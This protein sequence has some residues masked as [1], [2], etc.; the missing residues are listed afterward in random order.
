MDRVSPGLGIKPQIKDGA[1]YSDGT[2]ILAAD[3]VAGIVQMLEAVRVLAE[4]EIQH[5]DI[6]L[7][8]TISEEA[9]LQLSLIHI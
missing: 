9:G 4:Q 3:D 5:G 6:E 2:T 7:L 1:I 8:F